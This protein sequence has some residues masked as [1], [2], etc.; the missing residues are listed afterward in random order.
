MRLPN[1]FR[2]AVRY[3]VGQDAASVN[4]VPGTVDATPPEPV[5]SAD[6]LPEHC[7]LR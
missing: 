7:S 3:R 1:H 4:A 2:F 5:A 6:L